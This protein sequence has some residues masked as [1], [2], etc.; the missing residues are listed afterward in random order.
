MKLFVLFSMAFTI[1]YMVFEITSLKKVREYSFMDR[2]HTNI[3]RAIA[4]LMVLWGHVGANLGVQ[5]IQFI[6][7]I[8]V[9][10]F[11][12][13][14]GYGLFSSYEK[15]VYR[16][17][18][19]LDVK[20]YWKKKFT[21]I[22]LPF[23]I[24]EIL[25]LLLIGKFNF[26]TVI[27]DLLFLNPATSYGWYMQYLIICYII[28]WLVIQVKELMHLR[29]IYVFY[30][31]IGCFIIWF[32]IDSLFFAN[33]DMPFLRARQMLAFPLGVGLSYY[34][35]RIEKIN[36]FLKNIKV[37]IAY[38]LLGIIL[39]MGIT[40]VTQL[41]AIKSF[42]YLESNIISLF[43]VLPMGLSIIVITNL[44][45][46]AFKNSFLFLV[47]TVSY[48]IYLVHAFTLNIIDG[49]FI[50]LVIFSLA[51]IASVSCLFFIQKV[52]NKKILLIV[53]K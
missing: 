47:G 32:V 14:S 48:E 5:N 2:S 45:Q 36:Y 33:P 11:L 41:G 52:V 23:W 30:F 37:Q 22:I 26:Y 4:I 10:L 19:K 34:L 31:L 40:L 38:S 9:T 27:K 16:Y 46:K 29:S 6:G 51:T 3:I 50:G 24:V 18:M 17:G 28:F 1:A 15:N 12:F 53:S 7:G 44:F 39:G 25:G 35:R 42:P 21:K 8:G 20:D 43:T 49:T 13:L